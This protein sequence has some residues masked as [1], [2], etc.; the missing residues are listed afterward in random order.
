MK[1]GSMT[2]SQDNHDNHEDNANDLPPVAVARFDF[3][4]LSIPVEVLLRGDQPVAI[5]P[6][7][8]L[9][10]AGT[11]RPRSLL[12]PQKSSPNFYTP[13]ALAKHWGV[14][15]DKVLRFIHAGDLP[16]FNAASRQSKLPRYRISVDAVRE[17]EAAHAACPAGSQKTEPPR[18]KKRSGTAA[19][20]RYF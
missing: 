6:T 3:P 11:S 17:F 20:H 7:S 15:V 13:R 12:K 8:A 14:H 5:T 19:V 2:H 18:R 9:A 16:A 4:D 10:P 1:E